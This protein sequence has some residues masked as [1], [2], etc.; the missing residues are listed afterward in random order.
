ME[1]ETNLNYLKNLLRSRNIWI[2][3][4]IDAH[5]SVFISDPDDFHIKYNIDRRNTARYIYLIIDWN[6]YDFVL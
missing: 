2:Q 4:I 1:N 3:E 5:L 6:V